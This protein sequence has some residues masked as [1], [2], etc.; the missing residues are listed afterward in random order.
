[1]QTAIQELIK[2]LDTLIDDFDSHHA[3]E[4]A[5]YKRGILDAIEKAET[6]LE[7][8]K[9]N[10]VAFHIEVMKEGSIEEGEEPPNES[11]YSIIKELAI[12]YYDQNFSQSKSESHEN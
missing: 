12:R 8:E 9:N 7:K 11:D 4:L 5:A 1:M 10:L 3:M 2:E 6:F